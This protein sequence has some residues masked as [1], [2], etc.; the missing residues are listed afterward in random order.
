MLCLGQFVDEKHNEMLTAINSSP[1]RDET[2]VNKGQMSQTTGRY[3]VW[4]V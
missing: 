4:K 3:T 2:V 1:H